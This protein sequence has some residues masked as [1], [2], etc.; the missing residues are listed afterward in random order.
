MSRNGSRTIKV[1][2][3]ELIAKIEENKA[4][5]IESYAKAVIAYKAEALRQLAEI[6]TKVE[7]GE[8]RVS[9]QLTTPINNEKN[10]D[11]ILEMFNWEIES[12]VEL[13]QSEF[14]EYVLDETEFARMASV[15][16]QMYLGVR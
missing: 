9:L 3:A 2:K 8:L 7:A 4:R 10:Y 12:E 1:N 16:N 6:T 13:G 5:H 15:S 14:N 11:K